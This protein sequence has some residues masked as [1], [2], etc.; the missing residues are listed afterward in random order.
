MSVTL[1]LAIAGFAGLVVILIVAFVFWRANDVNL[2]ETGDEKPDWMRETPP[3]QTLEATRTEGQGVQIFSNVPDEKLAAPFAEQIEDILQSFLRKHP[4]L[5]KYHIDLGTA[6]DGGLE[7]WVNGEKF[8][9]I[10]DLPDDDL[11]TVFQ[12]AIE[13]WNRH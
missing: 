9:N 12:E 8:T 11:R 10:D 3:P 4:E 7:I 13:A 1:L 6:P 5:N 2:T